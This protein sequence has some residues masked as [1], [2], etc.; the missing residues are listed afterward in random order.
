MIGLGAAFEV[1]AGLS[2][3]APKWMQRYSLE[4]F[5]RLIHNPARLWRRYFYHNPRFIWYL[6]LQ[7]FKTRF[8]F[9]YGK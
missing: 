2:K 8:N 7:I 5:F 9:N 3:R 4:W 1:Y 6:C